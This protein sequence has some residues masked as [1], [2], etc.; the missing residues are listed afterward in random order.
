MENKDIG[1]V[2]LIIGALGFSEQI[3]KYLKLKNVYKL[4][5]YIF[6]VSLGFAVYTKQFKFN[7]Y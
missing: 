5:Y 1:L 4:V 3:I 2:L 7:V 6:V